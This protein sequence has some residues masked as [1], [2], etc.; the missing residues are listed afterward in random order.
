[1]N[2]VRPWESSSSQPS[3]SSS[4]SSSLSAPKSDEGFCFPLSAFRFSEPRPPLPANLRHDV[5]HLSGYFPASLIV[6][7]GFG[8]RV[9]AKPRVGVMYG[10]PG[11]GPLDDG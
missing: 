11:Y 9:I 6:G 7:G 4:S 5:I 2:L 3:P 8:R 10:I 1:M